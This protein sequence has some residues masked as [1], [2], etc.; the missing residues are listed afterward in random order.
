MLEQYDGDPRNIWN[1][2]VEDVNLLY[3]RFKEF[4]GIGDALAK[5]AQF[6]LV[7]MYGIAGGRSS[8]T[9][10]S[11]KPDSLVR[12]VLFRTGLID[13][14]RITISVRYIESLQL[15]SPADFDASAWKIGRNYCSL[16]S[17]KCNLCPLKGTCEYPKST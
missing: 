7:R 4:D 9:K 12:R 14:D 3:E 10:M 2:P 16:S 15:E 13:S 17:P 6:A 8:Q 1:V 5:M 11:V